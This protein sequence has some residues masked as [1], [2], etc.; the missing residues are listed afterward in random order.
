MSNPYGL[1]G[2]SQKS[3]VFQRALQIERHMGLC[4]HSAHFLFVQ[5]QVCVK[6]GVKSETVVDTIIDISV[7]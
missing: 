4:K 2:C 1:F 5:A 6:R 3:I 7:L